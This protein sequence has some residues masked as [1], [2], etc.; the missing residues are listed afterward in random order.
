MSPII[1]LCVYSCRV[2]AVSSGTSYVLDLSAR[3]FR[4]SIRRLPVFT[5]TMP[6]LATLPNEAV[7]PR[8]GCSGTG[9]ANVIAES[10][11]AVR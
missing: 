9:N 8:A 3:R 4:L 1:C 2:R 7:G 10:I 6:R 5:R 11:A